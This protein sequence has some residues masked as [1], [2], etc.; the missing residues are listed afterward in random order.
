LDKGRLGGSNNMIE[1]QRPI[2]ITFGEMRESGIRGVLITCADYRCS[3]SVVR[4]ADQWRSSL[5]VFL[6]RLP[7]SDGRRIIFHC[8]W[9]DFHHLR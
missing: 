1:A 3:H 8:G 6:L 7:G 2:K 4:S 5:S 9:L